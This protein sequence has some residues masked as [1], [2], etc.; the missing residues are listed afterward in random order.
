MPNIFHLNFLVVKVKGRERPK[1]PPS[2]FEN[3]PKSLLPTP[4]PPKR[5]TTKATSSSRRLSS[6]KDELSIFLE[7]DKI[8]SFQCICD[9]LSKDRLDGVIYYVCGDCI[10]IQSKEMCESKCGI[11]KVPSRNFIQLELRSLSYRSTMPY[12]NINKETAYIF[13]IIVHKLRKL[14]DI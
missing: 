1:D 9:I 5:L 2:I 3:L 7:A 10:Y 8:S 4:P 14:L 6:K 12:T 11:P 13:S